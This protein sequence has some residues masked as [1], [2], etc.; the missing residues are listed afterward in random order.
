MLKVW[1]VHAIIVFS[2]ISSIFFQYRC[3]V[4]SASV[5]ILYSV[6]FDGK[7]KNMQENKP[8]FIAS[9]KLVELTGLTAKDLRRLA[10]EGYIPT[11]VNG[12]YET[13]PAL[14]GLIR[15]F[16]E[17][18]EMRAR[19]RVVYSS[20]AEASLET[21]IPEVKFKIAKK[22]E[23]PC[24]QQDGCVNLIEFLRWQNE[25]ENDEYLQME[26]LRREGMAREAAAKGEMA[27][28]KSKLQK[29]EL[30]TLEEFEAMFRELVMPIRARLLAMPAECAVLCNPTDPQFARVALDS[31]VRDNIPKMREAVQKGNSANE[32]LKAQQK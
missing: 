32:E 26:K 10:S 22:N 27:E 23:C 15:W 13:G 4:I 31:W 16:R 12:L 20:I 28:R 21:G 17:M 5:E 24:F 8:G 9:I 2:A 19:S 6:H 29:K 11:A 1:S 7:A 25:H 30:I 3:E 18:R 14:L